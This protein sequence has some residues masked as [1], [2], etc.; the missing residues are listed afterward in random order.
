VTYEAIV[1]WGVAVLYLYT[2]CGAVFAALFVVFGLTRVD[3]QARGSS[4]WFRVIISPGTVALW[5]WLL[6]RWLLAAS[7]EEQP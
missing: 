1:E 5:P 4:I 7:H 3:E 6:R 2:A